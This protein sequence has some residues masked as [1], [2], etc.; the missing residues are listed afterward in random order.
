MCKFGVQ[1]TWGRSVRRIFWLCQSEEIFDDLIKLF[2]IRIKC[3]ELNSWKI[4]IFWKFSWNWLALYDNKSQK[5]KPFFA[6]KLYFRTRDYKLNQLNKMCFFWGG[7]GSFGFRLA[8][9]LRCIIDSHLFSVRLLQWHSIF[10]SN[11]K[12]SFPAITRFLKFDFDANAVFSCNLEK[13]VFY[14]L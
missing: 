13:T 3:Y 7:G 6:L 9:Y 2:F 10:F 14:F 11:L 1:K 4:G 5:R 12:L 8:M